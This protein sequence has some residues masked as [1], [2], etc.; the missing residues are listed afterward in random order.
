MVL[1]VYVAIAAL[2]TLAMA[3]LARR[4]ELA[5]LRLADAT[6]GQLLH[7]VPIEQAVLLGHVLVVGGTIAALTLVLMVKGTTG[8]ATP[9]SPRAVGSPL[10][11][12]PFSS[13]WPEPY[14]QS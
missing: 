8:S 9:I 5:I 4:R 1:L 12:A 10:S 13:A 6:C 11:A 2:N 7:R 3:A 14:C